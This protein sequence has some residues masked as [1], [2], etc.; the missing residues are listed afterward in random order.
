MV[1]VDKESFSRARDSLVRC[2]PLQEAGVNLTMLNHGEEVSVDLSQI[3]VAFE[4]HFPLFPAT[5]PL[6]GQV[7]ATIQ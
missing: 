3:P 7:G 5:I 4:V 2:K 6:T 1:S